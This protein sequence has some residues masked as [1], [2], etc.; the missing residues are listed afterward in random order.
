MF[1]MAKIKDGGTYLKKHLSAN[2]YY[3]EKESVVGQWVGKATERLMLSGEIGAHDQAFEALRNNRHPGGSGK[4]TPRDG[5]D[6]VKF[7]DFQCSAQKSVSIMAVTMGDTRLLAAHDA[8]AAVA[9]GELERFAAR[10]ENNFGG[11][12]NRR[13]SNVVAAAFRHTASRALDPQVHTHF[14]TANATWDLRTK[15]WRAL[16][17]FEMVSAIRYAGKVYQ[18]E[19]ARSCLA[20]GY[21]VAQ[22]RD[23]K[24]AIT[25]FEIAGVSSEIRGRFSKRR[26]EVEAGIAEFRV[27]FGREPTPSEIHS[28]TTETRNA[29]LAEI[30]TPAVLAAQRAQLSSAELGELQTLKAQ[31]SIRAGQRV[32]A[33]G[34]EAQSLAASISHLYERQSVAAGHA[35]LAEALNQNLGRVELQ[36]LH[37]KANEAGLV[38]L[39]D[40]PW[41]HQKLATVEGLALEKWAVDFVDRTRGQCRPLGGEN[42]QLSPRLSAEQREAAEAV[43]ASR[44]QVVCLRGAAGVG[45]S[46]VL[47]EIYQDLTKT[48]VPVFC[49]AP[50]SSAA[51][52][53][54]KDGLAATTLRA[55]L[56]QSIEREHE[57]LRG[58]VIICDEAG[59]TS[60]RQ[61]AELLAIAEQHSARILFLGD[62][63]Q[64]T[65]V[66]AGDFLRVLESHSKLHRVELT[67]IRR[68]E[69]KAYRAAV[70]CLAT[71]AARLGLER[72][73]DLGWVKEGRAGYLRGAVEDF[74]RLSED[75]RNPVRVLAV[76]PT[77][78][79]HE[80]FTTELRARLKAS[81][82]LGPGESI[83]AHEPLKWTATQTRNARNY[84]PGMIVTFNRPAKGF[85]AGES[86]EVSRITDGRV[87]VRVPNGERRLF[88]RSGA[89]S[90]ARTR[91]LEVAA[92]DRLLIRA[93]DRG[94][95]VLNGEVVTVVGVKAGMIETADGR[96]IDSRRFGDFAHGFAVTSHASQSK[97]VEHVV[98]A[99][100]RLTAKAAY[101]ACSRGQVSCMV[102]TPDKT[103]L[104][105]RLPAGNREATLDLLGADHSL[106]RKALDRTL[107]WAQSAGG[108]ARMLPEA[109]RK[110]AARILHRNPVLFDAAIREPHVP[111]YRLD[112]GAHHSSSARPDRGPSMSL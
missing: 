27:E 76:T 92:G 10:Q 86:S 73:D 14:V 25:G 20:L 75:G 9:F 93:N 74:M 47:R 102:H 67:A 2:D 42:V 23:N 88:L 12:L 59:L 32:P 34:R 69:N 91:Q 17:E 3:S 66:E 49:C 44:D 77:W 90:V 68:Q 100:E 36:R 53:L 81:G 60:N 107:A 28:I 78:T 56:G 31:A 80:A 89:F 101:V 84:E 1:T 48:G 8:A 52:T 39:T 111:Q 24:G 82:T 98:V 112:L 62:S 40:E 105:D 110:T 11:R 106:A 71:G 97:T 72:L 64:H 41:V 21:D 83:T 22:I 35:I 95:G 46:T 103:A 65:A 7:F 4:L 30:S 108:R 61:G 45:K 70:R 5:N 15:S 6:R 99:A 19:M 43:L 33:P 55:F 16:T 94:S 50:T 87:F 13:T 79:E 104:L 29:K 58:S 51:D 57:H 38:G 63:R 18:N 37:A 85:K 109:L 54:R 26:A 96:R